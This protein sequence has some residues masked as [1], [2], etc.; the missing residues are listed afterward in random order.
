MDKTDERLKKWVVVTQVGPY[1]GPFS[2][3]VIT[4]KLKHRKD[5]LVWH[6][7]PNKKLRAHVGDYVSNIV[8]KGKNKRGEYLV[9]YNKTYQVI[10]KMQTELKL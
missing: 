5:L 7:G 8:T 4:W 10:H 3:N 6:E 9:D 2:K 1:D